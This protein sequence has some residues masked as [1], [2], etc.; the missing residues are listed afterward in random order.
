MPMKL[1]YK[2][3]QS[4]PNLF[5][6]RRSKAGA[7]ETTCSAKVTSKSSIWLLLWASPKYILF[8][9]L[10]ISINID[11]D[12]HL[13]LGQQLIIDAKH[14]LTFD[15]AGPLYIVRGSGWSMMT[16]IAVGCRTAS[17]GGG[18]LGGGTWGMVSCGPQG[19]NVPLIPTP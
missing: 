1:P 12:A 3:I 2:A 7:T 18:T 17:I 13:T 15:Q 5:M 10:L 14:K 6:A 4:H 8:E 9:S 19:T 11:M 16:C